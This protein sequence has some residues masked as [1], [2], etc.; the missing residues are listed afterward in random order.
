MREKN[1][2]QYGRAL[3][4]ME[5][6]GG[7]PDVIGAAQGGYNHYTPMKIY[8]LKIWEGTTL[9]KDYVPFVENGVAI[10]FP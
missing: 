8:G 7:E 5:A 4:A 3:Q 1:A 9:V 10:P 6:S 2:A